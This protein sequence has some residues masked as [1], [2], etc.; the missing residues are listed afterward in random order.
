M[1]DH[2]NYDGGKVTI[3]A[4]FNAY[5]MELLPGLTEDN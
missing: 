1:P 4:G 2:T 5:A 3:Q